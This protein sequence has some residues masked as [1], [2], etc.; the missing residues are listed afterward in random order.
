MTKTEKGDKCEECHIGF[1]LKSGACLLPDNKDCP[2][3]EYPLSESCKP[4]LESNCSYYNAFD[5]VCVGCDI[6][7]RLDY[8]DPLAPVCT[9][10]PH[11]TY[12][13]CDEKIDGCKAGFFYYHLHPYL[14]FLYPC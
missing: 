1:T 6:D 10:D 4:I 3:G 12:A 2:L 13:N 8:A 14:S 7:Y 11:I 9:E 5:K